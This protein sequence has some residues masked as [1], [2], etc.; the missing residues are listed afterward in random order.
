MASLY[1]DF[2]IGSN[3]W[4]RAQNSEAQPWL[5]VGRAADLIQAG[6]TCFI[7]G[8]GH[9]YLEPSRA[10]KNW[11]IPNLN[12]INSGTALNPIR[13]QPYPGHAVRIDNATG[14][15]PVIGT[16]RDYVIWEGF[17]TTKAAIGWCDGSE[18]GYCHIVTTAPA[19]TNAATI[20][21]GL[22]CHQLGPGTRIHHNE[23]HGYRGVGANA[24]GIIVWQQSA[25]GPGVIED[26]NIYDCWVGIYTKDSD[27]NNIYRRNYIHD[28]QN[29]S[30]FCNNQL[31][32]A[33]FEVYDNFFT[34]R[35]ELLILGDGESFHDNYLGGSFGTFAP[36]I[37]TIANL[38]KWNNVQIGGNAWRSEWVRTGNE[39]DF[40]DYNFYTGT[41]SY[42]FKGTF[43]TMAQMQALG[44][45]LSSASGI[46]LSNIYT[47][48]WALKAPYTTAGRG[49]GTGAGGFRDTVGPADGA[50]NSIVA[51]ILDTSRYGPSAFDPGAPSNSPPNASFSFE[52]TALEV[53]VDASGS[54]DIDGTIAD[55]GGY[56]WNWGD[57][58]AAG[59]GKVTSHTY[60]SSGT[61]N[62]TLTVTD[63][64]SAT[65]Q[66]TQQVQVESSPGEGFMQLAAKR[67][68][69]GRRVYVPR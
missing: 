20:H 15:G 46:A 55:P 28:C 10:G 61:Y 16:T 29:A 41:P 45:E 31:A 14:G 13:F 65:D 49:G 22:I 11:N 3:S 21:S 30:F 64:D 34:Q 25:T 2:S 37:D 8:N 39:F 43:L 4:T 44:Y 63:D 69:P 68:S 60:A 7:K 32:D 27:L 9:T 19:Q 67:V 62:V 54:S 38:S 23:I 1:V 18:I 26:N 57:G 53:D 58:S 17:T 40:F 56:A 48:G 33:G 12:P 35:I 47:A 51:L 5:T 50:G 24:D 52:V 6:D 59:S 66:Q 42:E 36:D